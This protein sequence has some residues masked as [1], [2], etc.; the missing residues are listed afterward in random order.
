MKLGKW[1]F[2][3]S[4]AHLL[5]V[6]GMRSWRTDC[7]GGLALS[8]V[9]RIFDMAIRRTADCAALDV[10]KHAFALRALHM[11]PPGLVRDAG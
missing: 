2:E 8:A 3:C 4:L 10:P 1:T 5:A 6:L 7:I 11:H 9:R